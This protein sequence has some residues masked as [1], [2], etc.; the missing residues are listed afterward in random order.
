MSRKPEAFK[1]VRCLFAVQPI[2]MAVFVRTYTRRILT[3][4]LAN[5]LL[6]AVK[7]FI[8]RRGAHPLDSMTPGP[9]VKDIRVPVMYVQARHDPWTELS[10]IRSFYENTPD[11]PKEFFWIEDTVH[12][13]E[14]YTYF[15]DRPAKMLEWV[16]RWM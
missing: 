11:N 5:L 15:Q 9:Y 13:F 16:N 12:R 7:F 4:P 10:D 1:N 2:S 3:P 14:L 6:P 8:V